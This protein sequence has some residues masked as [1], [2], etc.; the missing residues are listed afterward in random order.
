MPN[1]TLNRRGFLA[2]LAAWTACS[3]V[4]QSA[5][6]TPP[7]ERQ[8]ELFGTWH[9]ARREG[10]DVLAIVIPDR[11]S[12][13]RGSVVGAALSDSA[14]RLHGLLSA[15]LP[16]CATR[17]ELHLLGAPVT[18]DTWFVV[19]PTNGV[20]ARPTS[21]PGPDRDTYDWD[22]HT[23]KNLLRRHLSAHL[24]LEEDRAEPRPSLGRQRWVKDHLPGSLWAREGGCGYTL[25][26]DDGLG[27]EMGFGCGMGSVPEPARR[28]LIFLDELDR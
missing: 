17:A 6:A 21:I 1:E 18:D 26:T 20:P 4:V 11:E 15:F 28:F 16:I 12:F 22:V 23:T 14:G 10:R 5:A 2:G 24:S 27:I 7:T 19:L 3:T 25:E 13:Y 8:L 9:Q